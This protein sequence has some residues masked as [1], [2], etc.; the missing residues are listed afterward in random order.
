[1]KE[2]A[3]LLRQLITTTDKIGAVAP[4]SKQLAREIVDQANVRNANLV[5]EFG[6]GTGAFTSHIL[7][8]K[9]R[10]AQMVAVEQNPDLVKLLKRKFTGIHIEENCIENIDEILIDLGISE[11]ADCIVCGLPWASFNPDLQNRLLDATYN[12]LKPGGVLATFAYLQ[13]MVLPAAKRFKKA[14]QQKF[15]TVEKS[16]VIWNNVPP[17]F[18][19]RCV[20]G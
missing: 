15:E 17:A 13:G 11:K 2:T 4:S 7:E 10:N 3:L 18:V 12:A 9:K 19:Y 20:K 16:K 14:I 8:A 1:M 6:P 5:L